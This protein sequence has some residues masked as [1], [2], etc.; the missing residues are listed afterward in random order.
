MAEISRIYVIQAIGLYGFF[1]MSTKLS[2]LR[3]GKK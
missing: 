3:N 2:T 1:K